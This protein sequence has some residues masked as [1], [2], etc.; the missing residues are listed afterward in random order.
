[1]FARRN[2]AHLSGFPPR[3]R[4]QNNPL[5]FIGVYLRYG[6]TR[7]IPRCASVVV[8]ARRSLT[9]SPL[10]CL[11]LQRCDLGH[12]LALFWNSRFS[13]LHHCREELVLR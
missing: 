10:L 9:H 7:I 2:P 12:V 1:M 5:A 3:S 4:D 13:V 11:S 6:P 8:P